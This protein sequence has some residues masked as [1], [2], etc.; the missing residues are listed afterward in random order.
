MS[1]CVLYIVSTCY[2]RNRSGIELA[3][4]EAG[5]DGKIILA[6]VHDPSREE[7]LREALSSAAFVGLKQVESVAH[8]AWESVEACARDLLEEAAEA[9]GDAPVEV[10]TKIAR[11]QSREIIPDLVRTLHVDKVIICG[12][13][14][15][16]LNR[17]FSRDLGADLRK[18]LKVPVIQVGSKER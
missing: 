12:R 5:P 14:K 6:F 1:S 8:A 3:K 4:A 18:A 11:G 13:K 15:R 10:E 16:M 17:I 7:N 9:I 2:K